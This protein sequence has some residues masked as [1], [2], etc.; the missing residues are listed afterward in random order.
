MFRRQAS[1]LRRLSRK[2]YTENF[3]NRNAKYYQALGIKENASFEEIKQAFN[4]KCQAINVQIGP[5]G[6]KNQVSI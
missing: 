6:I 2:Y 1:Y 5:E 3:I 4:N